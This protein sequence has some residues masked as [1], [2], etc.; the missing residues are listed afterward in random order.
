MGCE[1]IDKNTIRITV[2]CALF[3]ALIIIG[4]YISIPAGPVPLV[5][6]DFFVMLAGIVLGARYGA[7]SVAVYLGLGAIGLPVFAGGRAGLAVL[8]GPTGGFLVGY[9]LAVVVIG[10]IMGTSSGKGFSGKGFRVRLILA[11]VAGNGMLYLCGVP[12]LKTVSHMSWPVALA[13][14]VMPFLPGLILKIV[15]VFSLAGVIPRL[16]L[17]G[18]RDA[19]PRS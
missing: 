1:L 8:W 12:W 16:N 18:M 5:L 2:Y 7:V 15:A 14:G 13:T 19:C 9:L 4:G 10:L 17:W 11:L 3:T 6:A